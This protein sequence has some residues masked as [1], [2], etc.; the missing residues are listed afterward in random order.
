L[1]VIAVRI[2]PY[3]RGFIA[4]VQWAHEHRGAVLFF[5]AMILSA[6]ITKGYGGEPEYVLGPADIV[7]ITVFENPELTTDA[8]VSET[9][10]LSF[11]LI[12]DVSVVGLTPSQ[13]SAAIARKLSDGRFVAKP[14]VSILPTVVRGSQ[15]TVVGEVNK[16]GRYPLETVNTRVSDALAAAGGVTTLGSDTVYLIQ[17]RLG[18]EVRKPLDVTELFVKGSALD[19]Q[20]QGGDTIFLPRQPLVYVY[21]EVRTPGSYRLQR[22]MTV[23]Q[24]LAVGGGATVR[25]SQRRIRVYRQDDGG[26]VHEIRLNLV[27]LL[28]PNDV[29]YVR[30]RLF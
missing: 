23:M 29:I 13:A 30:P 26:K 21:G 25:G 20:V 9:G 19:E 28:Q 15:I 16:P 3:Y 2:D 6:A 12:G 1:P 27:D 10:S 18:K 4:M 14:Q 7:H 22:N 17:K 5:S 8:R 24:A 11:P